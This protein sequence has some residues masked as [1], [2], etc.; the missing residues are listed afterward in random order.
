MQ[1]RAI[2]GILVAL[3]AACESR[4]QPAPPEMIPDPAQVSSELAEV[5]SAPSGDRGRWLGEGDWALEPVASFAATMDDTVLVNT[6]IT[7][8]PGPDGL[9]YLG[10]LRQA[11]ITAVTPEGRFV[12]R[13]GRRG[14][15]PGE[16][17]GHNA[18]GWRNDSLWVL[19]ATLGRLSWFDRSG[20]LL[21]S[22]PREPRGA[23]PTSTG[24]YLHYIGQFTH[25]TETA[26]EFQPTDGVEPRLI[27]A[28]SWTRGGF[29]IP[30]GGGS[31]LVGAHPMSDGPHTPRHPHGRGLAVI[32]QPPEGGTVSITRY[33]PTGERTTRHVV[34]LPTQP[35]TIS[36][37]QEFLDNRFVNSHVPISAVAARVPRPSHWAPITATILASDD[38]LFIRGPTYNT[39][40]VPWTIISS[41]GRLLGTTTLPAH[42][43]VMYVSGD[44]LWGIRPNDDDLDV[45]TRYRLRW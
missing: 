26:I 19:D 13:I 6:I 39:D 34:E 12:R 24:G 36:Q 22:L 37:W 21:G 38:R 25:R 44:T 17:E 1:T 32:E 40:R 2:G 16:F 28:V 3:L 33:G 45:V 9:L 5:Q 8:L 30:T 11:S 31:S 4:D 42:L 20:E 7:L 14:S 15:G 23:W 27:H 35:M 41:D 18:S 29:Q 43:R 10:I